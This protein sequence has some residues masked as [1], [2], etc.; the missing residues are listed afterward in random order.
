MWIFNGDLV[1]KELAKPTSIF[2]LKLWVVIGICSGTFV[3]LVLFVLSLCIKSRRKSTTNRHS[4]KKLA[5][6]SATINFT[7]SVSKEIPEV[8]A[9]SSPLSEIQID[10]GKSEHKVV[11]GDYF[12]HQSRNLNQN[13]NNPRVSTSVGTSGETHKSTGSKSG[14]SGVPEVSHLGWGHWYTLRELKEATG[15]LSPENVIGEGGYGIV[16]RGVL[17]DNNVVAVKNLFNNR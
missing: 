5:L 14:G 2:G 16:Y 17:P 1:N 6:S 15:G 7:P 11:F 12:G 10:I 13:N 3:V 4:L 9:V 8:A